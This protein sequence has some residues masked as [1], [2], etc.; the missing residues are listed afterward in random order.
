[1]IAGWPAY[2]NAWNTSPM[3]IAD[4]MTAL[5]PLFIIGKAKNPHVPAV[6]APIMYTGR[7]PIVSDSL[8]T[9]G[10]TAKCT[11]CAISIHQRMCAVS[12]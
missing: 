4:K 2:M 9:N 12:A 7:R 1:M 10:I 5:C 11:A 8:P 6:T 3:M